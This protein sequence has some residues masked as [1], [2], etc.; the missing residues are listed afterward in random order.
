M[1]RWRRK[2]EGGAPATA[3]QPMDLD[4]LSLGAAYRR[5]RTSATKVRGRCSNAPIP[6]NAF[7]RAN[8]MAVRNTRVANY[9][10]APSVT[11]P[12]AG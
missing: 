3:M 10:G 11:V 5:G 9:L 8:R 7:D 12:A 1:R 6:A 4:L 2:A